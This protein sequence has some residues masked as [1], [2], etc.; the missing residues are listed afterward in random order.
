[1]TVRSTLLAVLSVLLLLSPVRSAG[2]ELIGKTSIPGTARD[3]SGLQGV[4]EDKVPRDRL[5]TFGS[6]IAYTGV[7]HRYLLV[8][9]SGPK[10][11]ARWNC[12][13]HTFEIVVDARARTVKADLLATTLLRNEK[14]QELIG[15]GSEFDKTNSP[16][17]LRFDPEGIRVGRNGNVLISDEFG[18]F[19]CAF[20]RDGQRLK[21]FD[22]P[23]KF[24]ISNPGATA[25]LELPPHNTTGRTANKGFEGLAISPDGSKLYAILQSPLLQDRGSGKKAKAGQN[26]RILE[27]PVREGKTR[28]LLYPLEA[29]KN[30]VNEILAVS[31]SRF[32][33]LER[34]GQGGNEARFKKLMLIDIAEASD[35]SGIAALP[36]KAVPPGVRPV[37][38][39]LFLDLLDPAFGLAGPQFPAKVEGIAFGPDLPDGRILLLA[40]SDNDAK[41]DEPTWI[42]AFAIDRQTL[43]GYKPQV[44]DRK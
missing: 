42:W 38:K 41:A 28:E 15:R 34:D 44:F 17:G 11:V 13:F 16:A 37:S 1:M 27:M 40:T 25:E 32:L 14:G 3:K 4:P 8:N 35:I 26:L 7:G 29:P 43:P 21:V 19:L 30:G 23:K 6:G 20:G 18:P 33:V 39:K 24:L 22:V 2:I 9:D 5:G 31:E 10:S 12:R 36:E